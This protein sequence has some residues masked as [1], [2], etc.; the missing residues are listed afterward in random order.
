[1][2]AWD[3]IVQHGLVW[4]PWL[5]MLIKTCWLRRKENETSAGAHELVRRFRDPTA[6]PITPA[7]AGRPGIA[8][9]AAGDD[10]HD[11]ARD[12]GQIGPAGDPIV[13]AGS[14]LRRVGP[15]SRPASRPRGPPPSI[16]IRACRA[17][18]RGRIFPRADAGRGRGGRP[19]AGRGDAARSP[20][21]HVC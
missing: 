12:Q 10:P 3:R 11:L 8:V 18:G 5:L 13:D 1:L 21:N 17:T 2:L 20:S 7:P 6:L 16:A 14:G 4:L 9:D 19:P 15:A